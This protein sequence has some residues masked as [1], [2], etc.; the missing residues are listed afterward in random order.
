M[1]KVIWSIVLLAI[2]AV[3]FIIFNHERETTYG[4]VMIGEGEEISDINIK[5]YSPNDDG[6]SLRL[7]EDNKIKKII[8]LP[9]NMKLK[10]TTADDIR[11]TYFIIVDTN[12]DLII[13]D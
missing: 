5:Y 4:E 2:L 1:K 6:K 9:S 13:W 11:E 12:K 8:E 3:R 7:T 10:R